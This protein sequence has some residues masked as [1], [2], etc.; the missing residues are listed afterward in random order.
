MNVG[1]SQDADMLVLEF[2]DRDLLDQYLHD[3]DEE[4]LRA[5]MAR[6][7]WPAAC[8]NSVAHGVVSWSALVSGQSA[9]TWEA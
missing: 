6:S 9:S 1:H 4:A 5:I 3:A 2:G 7:C 8:A